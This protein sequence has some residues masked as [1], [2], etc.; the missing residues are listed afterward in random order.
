MG[1]IIVGIILI[2]VGAGLIWG[3]ISALNKAQQIKTAEHRTV[4]ELQEMSKEIAAELGRGSYNEIVEVRGRIECDRPL[5][6]ELTKTECVYYRMK[7]DQEYEETY[8]QWDESRKQHVM[9]TRRTT[10]NMASNNRSVPFDLRDESGAVEVLPDGADIEAE[11]V[12]SSFEPENRL[13]GRGGTTISFGG[14]SLELGGF[15]GGGSRI[16][17]YRLEEHALP[18]GRDVYVLAEAS[19][20]EG[21]LTLHKPA[22]KKKSRFII[23]TKSKEALIQ[24]VQRS[25]LFFL[26]GSIASFLIGAGLLIGGIVQAL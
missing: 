1:L 14:F 5:T 4:A 24:S 3:R 25:A 9:R 15:R 26:I 22:S 7:V 16:L 20:A 10:R 23:T 17:G 8:Q 2:I 19:D 13:L 12:L 18:V 6:S 21:R 11:K